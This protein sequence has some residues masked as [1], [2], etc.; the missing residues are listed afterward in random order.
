MPIEVFE[1]LAK[2]FTYLY[3]KS[4][5]R[6]LVCSLPAARCWIMVTMFNGLM[7]TGCRQTGDIAIV[8]THPRRENASC[9]A[10]I[11]ARSLKIEFGMILETTL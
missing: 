11:N 9:M 10:V 5:C 6:R 8:A 1:L 4:I 2:F 3:F 7:Q